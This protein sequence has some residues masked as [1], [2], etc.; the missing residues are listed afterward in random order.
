MVIIDVVI[1]NHSTKSI[2]FPSQYNP[3][4][5]EVR[6]RVPVRIPGMTFDNVTLTCS[7]PEGNKTFTVPSRSAIFNLELVNKGVAPCACVASHQSGRHQLSTR[8]TLNYT[9]KRRTCRIV[10]VNVLTAG[11]YY[12]PFDA[13]RLMYGNEPLPDNHHL[14]ITYRKGSTA[15]SITLGCSVVG[16]NPLVSNITL[17]CGPRN[18]TKSASTVEI[19]IRPMRPIRNRTCVCTAKHITGLYNKRSSFSLTVVADDKL[20]TK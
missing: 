19:S 8:F 14:T 5:M 20:S 10:Y 16:G 4:L 11:N 18:M 6:C 7:F 13:P 3:Y 2:V 9:G 15:P 17:S 12:P 1:A